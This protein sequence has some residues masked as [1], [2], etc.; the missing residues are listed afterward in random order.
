MLNIFVKKMLTRNRPSVDAE[1]LLNEAE[2]IIEQRIG[3]DRRRFLLFTGFDFGLICILWIIFTV[4]LY[5]KNYFFF[6]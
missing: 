6:N 3:K 4:Y 1:L 2:E 5:M